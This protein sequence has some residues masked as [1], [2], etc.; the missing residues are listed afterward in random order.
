MELLNVNNLYFKYKDD[1][2]KNVCFDVEKGT[3]TALLGVNGAGK[4]TL[5]KNINK[6]L[7]PYKGSVLIEGK[8][9]ENVSKNDMAKNVSYTAQNNDSSRMTVYDSIL[10][11]RKP[12]I[13]FQA[14]KK[15]HN[16]VCEIIDYLDLKE[17]AL[18]YTNEL[19]G[20]EFQKV[21]I[22]RALAQEPKILLL[23]EPTSSLDLRNQ[24]DV[25]DMVRK[26][27]AK[28]GIAAIVSIHDINLSLRYADK[29]ILMDEGSVYGYGGLEIITPENIKKI[30]SVEV[31]L[32]TTANQVF[33]VPVKQIKRKAAV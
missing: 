4:S 32:Y 28:K 12:Y 23:D 22:A 16:I 10:I 11:G 7:K 15:D 19:S 2:L 9:T 26:Y 6:I 8:S 33:I 25:M 24:L 14:T 31:E 13:K 1:I 17:Y 18:R 5:L 30:Y 27:C 29:F 3:F 20:G 21:V